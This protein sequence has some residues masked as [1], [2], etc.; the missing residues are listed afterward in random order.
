MHKT[1]PER[2]ADLP[3]EHLTVH[4]DKPYI[5]QDKQMEM[6]NHRF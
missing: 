5:V 2:L 4:E 6:L 1:T 3:V